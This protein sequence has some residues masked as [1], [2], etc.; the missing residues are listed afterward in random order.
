M[1]VLWNFPRMRKKSKKEEGRVNV[2]LMVGHGQYNA[3]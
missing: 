3:V 2:V 1:C